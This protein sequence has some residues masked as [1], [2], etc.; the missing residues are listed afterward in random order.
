MQCART[1]PYS[2]ARTSWLRIPVRG[3]SKQATTRYARKTFF[4]GSDR[5][6]PQRD[7]MGSFE[8]LRRE[9][10]ISLIEIHDM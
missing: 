10:R 4:T 5:N 8:L 9:E 2:R 6:T 7:R 1:D 3:C